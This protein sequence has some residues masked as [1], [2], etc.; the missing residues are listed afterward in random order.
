MPDFDALLKQYD[1]N[2]DGLL[3][4]AEFPEKI[5]QNHR[6][7]LDGLPG[8][9]GSVSG[10]NTFRSADKNHDGKIDRTEW[11]E[12]LKGNSEPPRNTD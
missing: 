3:S 8:A 4:A 2:G 1:K 9:D 10:K 6:I 7:G 5:L 11:A 12:F